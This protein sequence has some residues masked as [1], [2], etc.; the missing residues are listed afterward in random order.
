MGTQHYMNKYVVYILNI[1]SVNITCLHDTVHH[2]HVRTRQYAI[3]MLII[4]IPTHLPFVRNKRK[5]FMHISWYLQLYR[6]LQYCLVVPVHVD[7]VLGTNLILL[8]AYIHICVSRRDPKSCVNPHAPWQGRRHTTQC[9]LKPH[10]LVC[11]Q[12]KTRRVDRNPAYI[13]I[14]M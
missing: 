13:Y 5:T 14:Y 4:F 11:H 9:H 10:E 12:M 3:R 2:W 8:N 7:A 6:L 1:T